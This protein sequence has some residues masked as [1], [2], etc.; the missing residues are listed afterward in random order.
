MLPDVS[1]SRG[2]CYPAVTILIGLDMPSA[3]MLIPTYSAWLTR[4]S[5]CPD[6]N[7][8]GSVSAVGRN[9][10]HFR[11]VHAMPLRE[12]QFVHILRRCWSPV[13]SRV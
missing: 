12:A 3:L 7:T 13:L 9:I 2:R 11:G 1:I 4:D 5:F 8:C 6:K 10:E